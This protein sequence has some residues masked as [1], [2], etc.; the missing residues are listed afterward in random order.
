VSDLTAYRELIA[1]KAVTFEP[2]G[3]KRIP[4]LN[5]K[6]FPHQAACTEFAL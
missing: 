3:L 2:K 1:R 4:A 5:S 6:M